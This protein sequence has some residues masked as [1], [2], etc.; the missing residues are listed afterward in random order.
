MENLERYVVDILKKSWKR[1][2]KNTIEVA[3]QANI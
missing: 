3:K 2:P 1:I